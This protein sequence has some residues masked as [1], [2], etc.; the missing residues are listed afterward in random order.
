MVYSYQ[1][2][3]APKAGMEKLVEG[4]MQVFAQWV[5]TQ[6]GLLHIHQLKDQTTGELVGISFWRSKADCDRM[7]AAAAQ[8]PDAQQKNQALASALQRPMETHEF[9]AIWEATAR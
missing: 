1:A 9:E 5:L 4:A 2:R 8:A 3:A 6:P 7:W